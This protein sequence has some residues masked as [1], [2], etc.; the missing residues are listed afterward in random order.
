LS[1]GKVREIT[2]VATAENEQHWLAYALSHNTDEVERSVSVSPRGLKAR[3]A[4]LAAE[5]EQIRLLSTTCSQEESS[6]PPAQAGSDAFRQLATGSLEESSSRTRAG[7]VSLR[8]LAGS[9]QESS[10]APVVVEQCPATTAG[11]CEEAL[12]PASPTLVKLVFTLTAEDFALYERAEDR[13]RQQRGRRISRN[14]VLTE[15]ARRVLAGADGAARARLPVVVRVDGSTGRGWF[16]T[17]RGLLPATPE[18]VEQALEVASEVV[19]CQDAGPPMAEARSG[20]EVALQSAFELDSSSSTRSAPEARSAPEVRPAPEARSALEVRLASEVGRPVRGPIDG[21]GQTDLSAECG[22]AGSAPR[23]P[24]R[25]ASGG[26]SSRHGDLAPRAGKRTRIP[27]RTLRLLMAR[28]GGRC[29]NSGCD[30]GAPLHIHH[31]L[32]VSDG[33]DNR[34]SGLKLLCAACHSLEHRSDFGQGGRWHRVRQRNLR[35]RQQR[36]S[37]SAR[38]RSGP[39]STPARRG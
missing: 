20:A 10:D 18:E 26:H 6:S 22:Q 9:P 14:Q 8:Q 16:D 37:G 30:R 39:G 5:S 25:T 34:L 3:R 38:A 23:S 7:S 32:P 24:D 15:L 36:R 19:C 11:P 2:R 28:S 4:A 21:Q 12:A 33:G 17:R 29:E 13:I 31:D 1:W 27:R 35:R